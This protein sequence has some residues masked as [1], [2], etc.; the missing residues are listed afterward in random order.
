[1]LHAAPALYLGVTD[2]GD[3]SLLWAAAPLMGLTLLAVG[4][5]LTARR[6]TALVL[7][8]TS[9]AL[10]LL[11]VPVYL[12]GM[13]HL[14]Q[15]LLAVGAVLYWQSGP[16]RRVGVDVQRLLRVVRPV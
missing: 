3:F 6:R 10:A 1:M 4:A 16:G 5:V 7:V 15:S 13:L 11:L 2:G 12:L 9:L 8:S 14:P